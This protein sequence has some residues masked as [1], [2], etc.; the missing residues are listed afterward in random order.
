MVRRVESVPVGTG[1]VESVT[2]GTGQVG[3]E[4]VGGDGRSCKASGREEIRSPQAL[5]GCLATVAHASDR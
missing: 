4:L 1:Q 2:V 5:T 3:T